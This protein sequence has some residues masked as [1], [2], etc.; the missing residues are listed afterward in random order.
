MADR[1]DRFRDVVDQEACPAMT[2]DLRHRAEAE[3]DHR[4]A[5]RQGLDNSEP[6]RLGEADQV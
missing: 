2:D 3:R 4:R 5:R 6:E 1:L